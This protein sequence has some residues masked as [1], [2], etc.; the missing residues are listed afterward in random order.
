MDL[1]STLGVLSSLIFFLWL[2]ANMLIP[3]LSY[4]LAKSTLSSQHRQLWL[5][6]SLPLTLPATVVGALSFVILAK[7]QHW[8]TQHCNQTYSPLFCTTDIAAN[9]TNTSL[10]WL[11]LS[12]LFVIILIVGHSWIKLIAKHLKVRSIAKLTGTAQRLT[13]INHLQP[14]A[15][16]LGV[17]HP[18]IFWSK[19]LDHLLTKTQQRIVLAHEIDHIRHQDILRNLLFEVFLAFHLQSNQLRRIWQFNVEA[20]VDDRLTYQF[21]RLDIAEVLLKLSRDNLFPQPGLSFSGL[22][23]VYRIERLL[24]PN[25]SGFS[26]IVELALLGLLGFILLFTI[27]EHHSIEWLINWLVS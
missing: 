12:L 6:V 17:R 13:K 19:K 24:H 9:L 7:Q 10:F 5:L 18:V 11:G 4:W 1:F 15:F 8:I 2:A 23:S 3:L 16:V 27:I 20:Q 22:S 25:P 26:G 21:D 14:Q